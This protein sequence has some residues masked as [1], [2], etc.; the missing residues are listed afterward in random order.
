M[1]LIPSLINR[2]LDAA[3]RLLSALA[4]GA[5][6]LA[7]ADGSRT[8][9]VSRAST[10]ISAATAP[11]ELAPYPSH[12]S[13]PAAARDTRSPSAAASDSHSEQSVGEGPRRPPLAPPPLTHT[14]KLLPLRERSNSSAS[15]SSIA[16]DA[17]AASLES[18]VGAVEEERSRRA[19]AVWREYW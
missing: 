12:P 15:L 3:G 6:P 9:R 7:P 13:T 19:T 5:T 10:P 2:P 18:R 14:R 4:A 11:L 1:T 16:S 8:S 17:S